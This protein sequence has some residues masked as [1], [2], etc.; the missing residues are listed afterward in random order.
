MKKNH[1]MFCKTA[2]LLLI[3][4]SQFSMKAQ[5]FDKAI[6]YMNY[7]S[8]ESKK[9]SSDMWSYTSAV[10]HS[11]KARKIENKRKD[12]IETVNDA[13]KRIS[14]MSDFNGDKSYRDSMISYLTIS[15]IVLTEDYS[16]I[17]DMEELTEQSYDKMEAYMT[18]QQMANDKIDIASEMINNKERLFATANGITMTE[19]KDKTGKNLEKAG[20]VFKYYNVLYLIFFKSYKQEMYLLDALQKKDVNAL[21]QNKNSLITISNEGLLKLNAIKGF[22]GDVTV[23]MACQKMLQ[24]YKKE[25]TDK[26]GFMRDF[27]LKSDNFNKQKAAFEEK[28]SHSN[29]ENNSYNK[30]VNDFNTAIAAFNKVNADLSK[31]R[32]TDLDGWNNSVQV[33]L[34]KQVP[35]K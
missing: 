24:F 4:C 31:E 33:F 16:K 8:N 32:S 17:I 14:K 18:A 28:K 22:K 35:K 34:D 23:K 2:L 15:N 19:E 20:E 21:E 12:L 29:E 26:V 3:V 6:D 10:A 9:I 11:G 25:A 1:T 13:K 7:I 5:K 30:V 27:I